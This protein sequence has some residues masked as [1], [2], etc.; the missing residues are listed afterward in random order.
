MDE[1]TGIPVSP[2][3]S[4]VDVVVLRAEGDQGVP[5]AGRTPIRLADGSEPVGDLLTELL[6]STVRVTTAEGIPPGVLMALRDIPVPPAFRSSPWLADSRPVIM[7]DG[8]GHLGELSVRY[9]DETGLHIVLPDAEEVSPDA[10][11]D[12]VEENG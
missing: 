6:D 3:D 11:E 2:L 10:G 8:T 12:S 7:R 9:T 5:V 4:A 1:D